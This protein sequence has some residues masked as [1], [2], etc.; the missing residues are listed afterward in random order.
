MKVFGLTGGIGA[1]KST[2]SSMFR[3]LRV[4]V[5]D[6]DKEAKRITTTD[7]DLLKEIVAL[8]GEQALIE[9]KFN[10]DWVSSQA[11]KHPEK[12]NALNALIHP[13]VK[14]DYQLWIRQQKA[15]YVLREAALVFETGM[16][17]E[18]DGVILVSAPTAQR[19][20][21][22]LARD[23][24]RDRQQV[25][26]IMERQMP[27]AEKNRKSDFQINNDGSQLLITQVLDLHEK[28]TNL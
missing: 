17:K 15:P 28:L 23:K 7:A 25:E 13:R 18:L 11:F 14:A 9:G 16:E 8:F 22:V 19:I 27:E 10:R 2:V 21:R 26:N 24:H 6:A 3:V 4:P 5:Y 12:L 20:E 1:G